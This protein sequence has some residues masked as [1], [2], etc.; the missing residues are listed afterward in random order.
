MPT[1]HP[2]HVRS[3]VVTSPE[4]GSWLL[5]VCLESSGAALAGGVRQ[6]ATSRPQLQGQSGKL[7]RGSLEWS[8]ETE[9]LKTM[10]AVIPGLLVD[11]DDPYRGPPAESEV[12]KGHAIAGRQN[13]ARQTDPHPEVT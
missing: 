1:S 4:S 9:G 8:A 6:A 11:S 2:E 10:A 7:F 3:I 5:G 12:R 13:I